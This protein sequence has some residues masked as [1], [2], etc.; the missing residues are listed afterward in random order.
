MSILFDYFIFFYFR[1]FK[2]LSHRFRGFKAL[3]KISH[4]KRLPSPAQGP[5]LTVRRKSLLGFLDF[6]E[7]ARCGQAAIPRQGDAVGANDH[8]TTMVFISV[9][10]STVPPRTSIHARVHFEFYSDSAF[11]SHQRVRDMHRSEDARSIRPCTLLPGHSC[12]AEEV[13]TPQGPTW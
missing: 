5:G 9:Q 7:P 3:Q 12:S 1:D 4:F 10:S 2:V 13:L 6:S 11:R 8:P